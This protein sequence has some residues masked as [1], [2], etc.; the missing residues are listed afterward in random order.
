MNYYEEFGL[1][2]DASDAKIRQSY[3]TLARLLHPDTQSEEA[4]KAMAEHQMMRVNG[5][6]DTLL[7]PVRRQA[8]DE[9][10][11]QADH[12]PMPPP[13]TVSAGWA[14][15]MQAVVQQWF[16]VLTG[17]VVA[18]MV[19]WYVAA[20]D[21]VVTE[22]APAWPSGPAP[23]SPPSL[24]RAVR[25]ATEHAFRGRAVSDRRDSKPSTSA[26]ELKPDTGDPLIDHGAKPMD[27]IEAP[28]LNPAAPPVAP[29][30]PGDDPG[31]A[32]AD[33]NSWA[34]SWIYV[35]QPEDASDA[36]P[37]LPLYIEFSLVEQHG[38]LVGNYRARYRVFNKALPSEVGF[39]A[40]GQASS[41]NSAELMWVS[42]E[43]AKGELELTLRSSNLLK[44][45]WWTTSFGSRTGLTSGTATLVRQRVR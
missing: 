27:M 9:A 32:A 29:A 44:V 1:P 26:R 16:W 21:L 33:H 38:S 25:P 31:V 22:V 20:N 40:E 18:A 2:P 30:T 10:L 4:V 8:Y 36:S 5:M 13:R 24:P 14:R 11:F 12:P 17:L 23:E 34:G 19:V 7:D 35:P 42:G 6:L 45:T 37:Y 28:R 41:G 39:K 15:M 43:G 3:K